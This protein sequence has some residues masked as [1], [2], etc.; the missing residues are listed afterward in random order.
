MF[1]RY[2]W[3]TGAVDKMHTMPSRIFL[4]NFWVSF[5]L[6]TAGLEMRHHMNIEHL[7][8]STDYPHSATDWPSSRRTIE[9]LF[10]GIPRDQVRRM[11][12]DNAVD[13]YGLKEVPE[14]L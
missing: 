4:R 8:F 3:F 11:L 7:M 14:R 5:M 10:R 9:K 13:L 6:D 12:R 1:Q 2:R